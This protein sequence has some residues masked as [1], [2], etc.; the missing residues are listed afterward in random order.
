M[1]ALSDA[2]VMAQDFNV[3]ALVTAAITRTAITVV[4]ED[5]NTPGHAERHDLAVK[6]LTE[7]ALYASRFAWLAS[8][9]DDLVA[10]YAAD[11]VAGLDDL[12]EVIDDVWDSAAGVA[13]PTP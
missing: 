10:A 3:H 11:G 7:P 4:N 13:E 2:A 12:Q 8:S 9:D 5:T 1:S 6:V